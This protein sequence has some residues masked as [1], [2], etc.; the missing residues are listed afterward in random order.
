MSSASHPGQEHPRKKV[1][2]A[3]SYHLM[4]TVEGI[5]QFAREANWILDLR[6]M[7]TGFLPEPGRVDGILCLLGGME[8]RPEITRLVRRARV[9]TVDLHADEAEDVPAARVLLN[10]VKIGQLAAQH[11]INRGFGN[12]LY[13]CRSLADWSGRQRQEGFCAALDQAGISHRT[14]EHRTGIQRRRA[15]DD[16]LPA[17]IKKLAKAEL[18]VAIFA[19]N[20]DIAALVL[21]AC[22]QLDIRVPEQAAVLGCA[23]D[24]MITEF[25][26]VPLSSVDPDLVGRAYRAAQLL[27]RM[28]N[29]EPPPPQ[30]IWI[31]PVGVEMR[32][33]TDILAVP[34]LRAATA[35]T[36]IRRN[37]TDSSLNSSV[38]SAACGIAERSLARLFKRY[39]KRSVAG[40]ISRQR[41]QLAQKML[42]STE[43]SASEIARQCGFASLLHLR[44]NLLRHTKLTPRQWRQRGQPLDEL[45]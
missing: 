19:E 33:S 42:I 6:T 30:P 26:R 22:E 44:R 25:A 32:Q 15:G 8:T 7:R 27:D 14:F 20:D 11:F 34:D 3:L 10:N 24:P 38:V 40:E 13:V 2:L 18:P 9:P 4:A 1:L 45:K 29:G 37:F 39:F 43:L 12:C 16:I 41:R 35:L 28:M 36:Y 5:L 17:M 23:N 31:E 21:D